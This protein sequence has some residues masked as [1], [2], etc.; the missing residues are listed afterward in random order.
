MSWFAP[1]WRRAARLLAAGVAASVAALG[2]V[3]PAAATATAAA[4]SGAVAAAV[5]ADRFMALTSEL[6]C[7]VCQNESLA[8]SHAPLA[9]DLKREIRAR[10][11]AGDSDA[12]ILEFLVQRYGDFVTYRPPLDART[13]LLWVGPLLLLALGAGVLWRQSRRA[14]PGHDGRVDAPDEPADGEPR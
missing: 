13:G 2:V 7:L 10:M 4:A 11:A 3:T 8:D 6:R 9:E 5:D 12:Q 1:R 14:G